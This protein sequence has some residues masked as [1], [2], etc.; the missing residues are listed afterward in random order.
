MTKSDKTLIQQVLLDYALIVP[1]KLESSPV[2]FKSEDFE[3]L[4]IIKEN[5]LSQNHKHLV[6]KILIAAVITI[7]IMTTL[8]ACV[9]SIRNFIFEIF[10]ISVDAT[11]AVN[12]PDVVK[13]SIEEVY[14]FSSLYENYDVIMESYTS[15]STMIVWMTEDDLTVLQQMLIDGT[16]AS[17]DKDDGSDY[18]CK[19]IGG[20]SIL[21]TDSS[22]YYN[23]IWEQYGYLFTFNCPN[24]LGWKFVE[25]T[26][27]NLE[28]VD[29]PIE[30]IQ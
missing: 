14:S 16:I 2:E 7:S 19:N 1:K 11:G 27:T 18:G 22:G 23:V 26:I 15:T 24:A 13:H 28:I 12:D 10:D 3:N 9:K 17:I 25:E 6:A 5:L 20:I 4:N 8:I 21:Y 29:V 30:P